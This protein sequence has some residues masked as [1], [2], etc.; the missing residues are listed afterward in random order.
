MED[1]S[2]NLEKELSRLTGPRPRKKSKR[3][4]LMFVNDRGRILSFRRFKGLATLS[5]F[6]FVAA[7][8]ISAGLYFFYDQS[9]RENRQLKN[10]LA[11]S[12]QQIRTLR[13]DKEKLAARLI[14][15]ESRIE[16]ILSEIEPKSNKKQTQPEGPPADT[17]SEAGRSQGSELFTQAAKQPVAETPADE[18]VATVSE[19]KPS[20][21]DIEAF[22][23]S[24]D[25]ERNRVKIQFKIK[26][27]DTQSQ[28]V[29]GY[30]FV[31]LKDD[32][33]DWKNWVIFPEVDMV[34]GKPK[35]FKSG[36]HF[37]IS[38]FK[39]V[40]LDTQGRIPPERIKMATVIV[41]DRS[42]KL[43]LEK[44]FSIDEDLVRFSDSEG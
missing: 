1:I 11:V 6:L 7:I 15:A 42:G 8:G 37:S 16:A 14:V 27:I 38:R 4:I 26:N 29:S 13:S 35:R 40:T 41:Y 5:V 33:N 9:V 21:V 28:P 20:K 19:P 17:D 10:A 34:S 32:S 36:R 12:R 39:T 2:K 31:L 24:R 22:S 43:M 25:A 18:P 44:N 23:V 30:T 3:W